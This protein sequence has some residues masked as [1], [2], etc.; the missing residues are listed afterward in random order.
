M[1]LMLVPRLLTLPLLLAVLQ[2]MPQLLRDLQPAMLRERLARQLQKWVLQ[3]QR[4]QLRRVRL[5]VRLRWLPASLLAGLRLLQEVVLL[6]PV[7][8]LLTLPS[9]LAVL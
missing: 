3:Q 8:L 6:M 7:P 1:L 4:L 2:G 5:K 9:L